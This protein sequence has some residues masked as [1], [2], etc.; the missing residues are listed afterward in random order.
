MLHTYVAI[1][2]VTENLE[3]FCKI[4][5][6]LNKVRGTRDAIFW[7]SN[8]VYLNNNLGGVWFGLLKSNR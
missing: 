6:E 2:D 5:L 7:V 1:F 8:K 4:V 3:N